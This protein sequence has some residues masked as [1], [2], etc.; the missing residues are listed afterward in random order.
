MKKRVLSLLLAALIVAAFVPLAQSSP[1]T[2]TIHYHRDDGDYE[3]WNIWSWVTDGSAYPFTDEDKF[4]MIAEITLDNPNNAPVGFIV[5]TDSWEKDVQEDRFIDLAKGSE[6]WVFS[7]ESEFYYEAPPGYEPD[8]RDFENFTLDFSYFRYDGDYSD[9]SLHF[10]RDEG[11]S[12]QEY[13][14]P[15][16]PNENGAGV[17][18]EF[19]AMRE[20]LNAT[21]WIMR[22]DEAVDYNDTV[23]NL[24]RADENERLTLYA[25]QDTGLI[26]AAPFDT[27]P[28]I[29]S[30]TIEGKN[31]IKVTTKFPIS[32][33]R[34]FVIMYYDT[35]MAARSNIT[36][37]YTDT[38]WLTSEWDLDFAS[39]YS[40]YTNEFEAVP[41]T[42]G[43]VFDSEEFER[44]FTYNGEL[45]VVYTDDKVTF[46]L[47]APTAAKAN[48][49]L[50]DTGRV[51]PNSEDPRRGIEMT[52]GDNGTWY[53]E[54]A[55]GEYGLL[56]GKFYTYQV[57]IGGEWREAVDPYAT[58]VGVNGMR[59]Q[60]ID[61]KDTDPSGW[62]A[63]KRFALSNPVDAVIYEL[64][65]RD[66]S[67]HESSGIV[68]RGK[69]LGI[70]ET[71]TV[72]PAGEKTG[73]D[74]IIDLGVTHVHLLPSYDYRTV[75]ELYPEDEEFNWGYDPQNY[76]APEGS[77]STDAHDGA[78]RVAE[79]K[80][81]VKTLHDNGIGVVMD[82]VYNHVYDAESSS[83]NQLVP[84]YYFRVRPDGTYS[85]GSGCGNETASERAM[86]RKF[87]VDSV[88][89]WASEYHID[90][91]R[92][93]LMGL[94]DIETMNLIRAELD[95][96]D[97]SIMVYGEGWTGGGTPLPDPQQALKK[98]VP[99]L[100]DRVA[101]FSDDIRD[102][103]KG[104]VFNH[105]E[106]GFVN[107]NPRRSEDIRFGVAASVQHPQVNITNV[108]YSDSFWAN[109]PSQT[110]SY[111]SAHDNLTLWDK[112][113]ATNPNADDRELA[114]M[115]RL[116]AAIVLTS[117]GIPFFQAGEEM[118]RTKRG[119]EN[120]YKSPDRVNQ[121]DWDRKSEFTDLYN[122]Y[123][124]LIELRKVTSEFR[125]RSADEIREKIKFFDVAE[126]VV[127]YTIG[128]NI[129]VVFNGGNETAAVGLPAS[130]W[131]IL[132]NEVKA[133]T[134]PLDSVGVT[135]NAA[136][137]GAYV[138]TRNAEVPS[139]ATNQPAVIGPDG[140][141]DNTV[142]P[143][144]GWLAVG[145]AIL[146]GAA[147]IV[148]YL[149][150][151]RR[152]K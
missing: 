119:D 111:A 34:E 123:K 72:S 141:S 142:I 133:G 137:K 27:E 61:L 108:S 122:Y 150:R 112:L 147:S 35:L 4:G 75:N 74:H 51:T 145:A 80:Q 146:L 13:L 47:W 132:V 30:A 63:D 8:A 134:E 81:M 109:Q 143:P 103:I 67:T 152:K 69:F 62:D 94:H 115:N 124:G 138:L 106:P 5:R 22:G 125:M 83:F 139:G 88:V 55:P 1:V 19:G 107:G 53:A 89:Y 32:A 73:L 49:L 131:D 46:T 116:S 65:V 38:F 129:C 60:I 118:A 39:E 31:S 43:N 2:V 77:Y 82:V 40:L 104:S 98:N 25:M 93:D 102:G 84:G 105:E 86:M 12:A 68:N 36:S 59:G 11:A 57:L 3:K 144:L 99:F 54:A 70:A 126:G 6:I 120:S 42:L 101:A 58:A 16:A 9:V 113:Q 41:I 135:L 28:A 76:N 26:S 14:L 29:T 91:F 7:G 78:V 92:F 149:F 33:D 114:A 100:H 17:V 87:M 128:D 130:G 50:Y 121:L 79:F 140:E 90:G 96:I 127:A 97:P 148:Y 136:P 56:K 71:G 15:L 85:N 37:G 10:R 24:T 48:V 18:Y 64:H 95:K 20:A 45:G 66:L 110:I 151:K 21:V 117:Q 52:R 44:M 23:I